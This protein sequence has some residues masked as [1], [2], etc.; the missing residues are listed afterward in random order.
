MIDKPIFPL[1]PESGP[2][3]PAISKGSPFLGLALCAGP[4]LLDITKG[5]NQIVELNFTGP[6]GSGSVIYFSL[7]PFLEKNGLKVVKIDESISVT[8]EHQQY[9]QMVTEQK[10][11]LEGVIKTGLASASQAV[12]DASLVEHD[13]RKYKEIL[14]YFK[15]GVGKGEKKGNEHSLRAMF[16]D[17]VDVHTGD[18]VAMVSVVQRWPTIIADFMKLTSEDNA[19]EKVESRLKGISKAEAVILT[20]KNKL[21]IEW[22][23]IFRQAAMD[24]Y[25]QLKTLSESRKKT[26]EEYRNWLKPYI[27]RFKSMKL[28]HESMKGILGS[29]KN[30]YELA[31]QASFS[32]EIK[33]WVWK[34]YMPS[35]FRKPSTESTYSVPINDDFVVNSFIKDEKVGLANFY[36]QLNESSKKHPND[37]TKTLADDMIEDIIKNS[38]NDENKLDKNSHY[39]VFFEIDILRLGSKIPGYEMEDI[40]FTVKTYMLSQNI[41]LVKQLELKL[42]EKEIENYFNQI[43]G[44]QEKG[45][46][47][48]DYPEL[49]EKKNEKNETETNLDF[50]IGKTWKQNTKGA[51]DF[52]KKMDALFGGIGKGAGKMFSGLNLPLMFAKRGS[53]VRDFSDTII[54]LFLK[55]MGT[56]YFGPVK[57]FIMDQMKIE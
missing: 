49:M 25:N 4:A 29:A 26:V 12:A 10:R 54:N 37:K 50:G 16:I 20:T 2:G 40:T 27:A 1:C 9:Y 45:A 38:W 24:R 56:D 34:P 8:P 36:P 53:Y 52:F 44:L 18:R 6:P 31:G 13:L 35:E 11:Q 32:N 3:V 23:K 28:G 48:S 55:P 22:A 33:L 7:V 42:R 17:Q 47:E 46:V 30:A 51:G 15:E 39:Y 43:L 14:D 41:M 5:S 57:S 21:F 19:I